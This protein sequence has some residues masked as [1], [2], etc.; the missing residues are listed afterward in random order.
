MASTFVPFDNET[1]SSK[2]RQSDSLSNSTPPAATFLQ[3]V[4]ARVIGT[5]PVAGV[6]GN[7]NGRYTNC[8]T[9]MPYVG[10]S[11]TLPAASA[12]R[13]SFVLQPEPV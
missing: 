2:W 3:W 11:T 4:P 9:A 12:Y 10:R 1:I 8:V 6:A 5:F 7:L 13:S